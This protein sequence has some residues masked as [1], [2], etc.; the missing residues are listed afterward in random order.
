[1]SILDRLAGAQGRRDE[2]PNQVL[3]RELADKG[4]ES[5]IAEVIAG[6]KGKDRKVQNDCIKVLY[7]IG[8]IVPALIAPYAEDFLDLLSS[9][10]NRLI[11]G[12]MAA[13]STI[14]PLQA[15]ILFA[16]RDEITQAIE[17]GSV[18]TVD[19][20]IQ[21]LAGVASAR[22][23]YRKELFP[24]LIDHLQTCRPKDV[25]QHSEKSLPAVDAGNKEAF[26]AVLEK[27]M[28]LKLFNQDIYV[29]VAGGIKLNQPAADLAMAASIVSSFRDKAVSDVVAMGEI[30]LTGEVR[31][32]GQIE[33]RLGECAKMGFKKA[34]IP[35]ANTRGLRVPDGI[36]VFGAGNVF[37][38]L[39][40]L[41]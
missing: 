40:I 21:T 41:I 13:L 20:G 37:D 27:R 31:A 33:K 35:N 6:V 24:F 11:W 22:D 10:N 5:G 7:E 2:V 29:N 4:D 19:G 8:Y 39:E 25:P 1:M 28:G 34:V 23:A 16:R 30:G 17:T 9:K 18:I 32:V 36:Q 26:I 15:D 38:A 12:A 14:A 3:A